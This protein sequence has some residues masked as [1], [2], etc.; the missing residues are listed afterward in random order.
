M[1]QELPS[2]VV[3]ALAILGI[4]AFVLLGF[5]IICDE[6]IQRLK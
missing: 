4:G 2:I 5:I 6:I 1:I 3:M